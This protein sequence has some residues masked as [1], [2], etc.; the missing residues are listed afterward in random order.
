MRRTSTVT[1]TTVHHHQESQ[2]TM[3]TRASQL[4]R[5]FSVVVRQVADL[6]TM[7]KDYNALAAGLPRVLE[8]SDQEASDLQVGPKGQTGISKLPTDYRNISIFWMLKTNDVNILI[9]RI[10]L[11]YYTEMHL[12]LTWDWLIAIMDSTEA[13]PRLG[14]ALCH[15]TDPANPNH[16]FHSNYVGN[17]RERT[18]REESRI[19]Q[20]LDRR[21]AR[22][23][24]IGE[25]S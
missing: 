15:I 20:A 14:A 5:A 19:L 23:G 18:N 12:S 2:V 1:T 25:K 3:T 7:I 4:A 17:L 13:Q 6:L 24:T 9:V 11:Q 22:F 10:L 8:I 21:R 16:P